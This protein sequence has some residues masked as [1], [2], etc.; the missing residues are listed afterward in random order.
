[1]MHVG[2]LTIHPIKSLDG[3]AVARAVI[4]PHGGFAGDREYAMFDDAGRL[5]N[6]KRTAAVHAIR[7]AYDLA[8]RRVTLS[9]AQGSDT[10]TLGERRID[11]WLSGHFGFAVSIQTRAEAF[12]DHRRSGPG[13]TLV[14]AATLDA[15][16]EMLGLPA[17]EVRARFRANIELA[18]TEA[19]EEDRFVA[20]YSVG[21]VR[22]GDVRLH[23]VDHCERCVVPSRDPRS[24]AVIPAFAKRLSQ[25]REATLPQWTDRATLPHF[26]HLAV[27]TRVPV[28]EVGK[29]IAAGDPVRFGGASAEQRTVRDRILRLL[30]RLRRG[31]A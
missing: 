2:G 8:A 24:G 6:G 15:A 4:A 14:S 5:V 23:A 20:A 17:E 30:R 13:P 10:F 1:M 7:A 21:V 25:W 3:A 27:L 31:P 19:F 18:G 26:Y 22:C 11:E 12:A 29:T 16:A 9:K 28:T